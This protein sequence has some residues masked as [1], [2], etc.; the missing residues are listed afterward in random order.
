MAG[1]YI[2]KMASL[3][4]FNTF[5]FL[6]DNLSAHYVTTHT[7]TNA[8]VDTLGC[9]ERTEINK[10]SFKAPCLSLADRIHTLLFGQFAVP[11]Q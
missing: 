8:C 5:S 6:A 2:H 10:R 4:R 1:P 11:Y 9:K 3:Y 7:S